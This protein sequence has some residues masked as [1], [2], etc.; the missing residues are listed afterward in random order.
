MCKQSGKESVGMGSGTS[1][2]RTV[3]S[4]GLKWDQTQVHGFTSFRQR[5][6][7]LLLSLRDTIQSLPARAGCHPAGGCGKWSSLQ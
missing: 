1:L 5:A 6:C 3:R 4:K 2:G 7:L